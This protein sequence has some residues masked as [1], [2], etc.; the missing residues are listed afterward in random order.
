LRI[1]PLITLA[2]GTLPAAAVALLDGTTLSG[3]LR[4]GTSGVSVEGRAI[5]F[6][7]CDW[8][9]LGEPAALAPAGRN[10]PL[11]VWLVDGSW[12]PAERIVAAPV[13]EAIL[14]AG[15]LGDLTVPLTAVLGWAAGPLPAAGEGDQLVVASGP[16]RGQVQGVRDGRLVVATALDPVPLTLAVGEVQ[17]LR[18]DQPQRKPMVPA[19]L[20]QTDPRRPPLRLTATAAPA[21]AVAATVTV[22]LAALAPL[23][24]IVEGPNRQWLSDV[25]PTTVEEFGAFGVVWPHRRDTDL[26]GAPII[27]GGVLRAKGLTIHSKAT[28]GW[29]LA[30]AY[31][32]LRATVGIL[33][34]LGPEGDCD[35]VISGDGRELW[36]RT[37][38][39]G[40]QPA[41]AVAVDV[42]GVKNLIVTV[43]YGAR[44]DIGDHLVLADAALIRH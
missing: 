44:Y 17:A 30:G 24:L 14:V 13:G 27:L 7:A 38:I 3:P 16:L 36:R 32:Q 33:D 19:L 26:D 43:D 40:G 12:L 41:V 11:G 29:N 18:L 20:V 21:L 8:L 25:V 34:V 35:L 4:L 2:V 23:R 1:L 22:D 28:L 15:P 37:G 10:P 42:V 6:S 5:P 39:R 31:A 9:I